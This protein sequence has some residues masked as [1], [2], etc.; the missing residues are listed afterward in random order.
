MSVVYYVEG[1]SFP[2]VLGGQTAC[3]YATIGVWDGVIPKKWEHLRGEY[4]VDLS[5]GTTLFRSFDIEAAK[6]FCIDKWPH[7]YFMS[8]AD[9]RAQLD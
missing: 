6:Q 2:S 3:S 5:N 8:P 1:N 9:Y 4:S 7:C